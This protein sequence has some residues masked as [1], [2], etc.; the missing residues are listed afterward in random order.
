[1][2]HFQVAFIKIL[3]QLALSFKG[4]F[5]GGTGGKESTWQCRTC[6]RH[7]FGPWVRKIPWRRKWQPTPV[8]L[9]GESH[10][11]G[12]LV[13]YSPRGCKE[14][15]T[16]QHALRCNLA[17]TQALFKVRY[18]SY[19]CGIGQEY[20]AQKQLLNSISVRWVQWFFRTRKYWMGWALCLWL[21]IS[22]TNHL[23]KLPSTLAS[24]LRSP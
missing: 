14:S 12:S 17:H 4:S 23:G 6:R 13:G 2:C 8:F 9:P 11:Q 3:Q 10:G 22:I 7:G 15:D 1:M 18:P 19:Q 5:P 21:Y 20:M 16:T 24:T